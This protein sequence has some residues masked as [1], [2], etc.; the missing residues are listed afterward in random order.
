[1]SLN[2]KNEYGVIT[3]KNDIAAYIAGVAVNECDGVIGLVA[4]NVKDGLVKL[5]K[6]DKLSKG[7]EINFEENILDIDV[8]I[9]VAYGAKIADVADFIIGRVKYRVEEF[10]GMIV[11]KVNVFVEGIRIP[12]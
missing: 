8:H 4:K 11:N 2:L 6:D 10:T 7:V 5:L 3:I 12:E 1:M 9:V